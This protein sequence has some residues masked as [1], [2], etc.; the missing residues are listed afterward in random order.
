MIHFSLK[1]AETVIKNMMKTDKRMGYQFARNILKAGHFLQRESMKIVP[2]DEDKLRGSAYTLP[3]GTGW[4][5]D[6]AV[7]Y[8][9]SY[10][11][12]AHEIINP[13]LDYTNAEQSTHY[14]HGRQFNIKHAAKIAKKWK[15]YYPGRGPNEQAK[16]LEKPFREK[17]LEILA[18]IAG[19]R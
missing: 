14:A 8:T 13:G 18:I 12:Y 5:R 7:G 15:H 16:F 1:G 4:N 9:A 2:I 11:V 10:A 3:V 6:V 17:R 19:K